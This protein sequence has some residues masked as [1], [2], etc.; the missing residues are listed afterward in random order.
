[1]LIDFRS[2]EPEIR[3]ETDVCIVGAGA[4]GITIARELAATSLRVCLVESGGLEPDAA[5]QELSHGTTVGLAYGPLEA[6][7]VRCLGGST[8]HWA[9]ELDLP[10]ATSFATRAWVPATGWPIG[11]E[12]LLPYYR[13]ALPLCG[14]APLDALEA[15]RGDAGPPG[16]DPGRLVA[17]VRH[18]RTAAALHFGEAYATELRRAQGV[19]V[20]LH[21]TATRL[22]ASPAGGRIEAVEL[23]APRGPRARVEARAFVLACGGIENP[24]LLLLSDDVEPA[25]LGNR[26]GLVGR[27]FM[28][29]LVFRLGTLLGPS[30]RIAPLARLGRGAW[31]RIVDLCPAPAY[32]RKEEIL[33]FGAEAIDLP[34]EPPGVAA[35]ARVAR[36]L[37]EGRWPERLDEAIWA[38]LR[39]LDDVAAEAWTRLVRSESPRRVAFEV[40]QE[41]APHPDNRVTLGAERDALGQRRAVLTLRVGEL[42]RRT[43]RAA[44]AALAR[45]CGR[46][47][48]GRLH[49]D[50]AP[51]P[52]R[53]AHHHMGTTRMAD[54]PRDGVVDRSGRVHG[55][56]NLYVAGSSVFPTGGYG[57]PTL[58]IVALALRLAEH[59]VTRL[60]AAPPACGAVAV[61]GATP[62][63]FTT[64]GGSRAG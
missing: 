16:L 27:C 5:T 25:G 11:R 29:H 62:A 23:C 33:A 24:R 55:L 22:R 17:R 60:A 26:H 50:D 38:M 18:F 9:G 19:R 58:T 14:G 2:V 36:R 54:D 8:Q 35:A 21:G 30:A 13:R 4:A 28:E 48:L 42:E 53:G 39:D 49:L 1:M 31:T 7:R 46:L 51:A 44:T 37:Q 52:L 64:G 56:E 3:F 43:A 40:M 47:G 6:T 12:E 10:E 15:W 34:P 41:Q 45:E 63:R 32:Q 61:A 20:L 59:L 57:N